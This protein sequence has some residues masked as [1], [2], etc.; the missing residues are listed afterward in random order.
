MATSDAGREL[1]AAIEKQR[2]ADAARIRKVNEDAQA[3][4]D[5]KALARADR[6]EAEKAEAALR[7]KETEEGRG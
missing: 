6:E 1:E 7:L 2:Q 3:E 5:R 4:R